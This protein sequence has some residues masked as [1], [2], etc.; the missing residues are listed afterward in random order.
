MKQSDPKQIQKHEIADYARYDLLLLVYILK[1]ITSIEYAVP[2]SELAKEMKQ[3]LGGSY[4]D[5]TLRRKLDNILEIQN[6]EDDSDPQKKAEK[7]NIA[8]I[9]Y[10]VYGGRVM[11]TGISYKKYYFEPCLDN[12]SMQMLN[13]T[14][15]SNRF[16][17][18]EEKAY[19]LTRM[20]MLNM[21]GD[22]NDLSDEDES[23]NAIAPAPVSEEDIIFPGDS[24]RF[25]RNTVILDYSISERYQV[26]ITYGTYDVY[27]NGI[28]FHTRTQD[29]NTKIYRLNPYALFWSDG[30]YYLLATYVSGYEPVYMKEKGTPVNFR[31]DRIVDVNLVK[32]KKKKG[33][34]ASDRISGRIKEFFDIQRVFD[35]EAYCARFP[36]MRIS[37]HSDLIDCSIECTPWSLQ[38]LV[39]TFGSLISVKE[40]RK[41]HSKEEV[42]YNGR[43]Q[44]F[45]EARIEKVEFENMRDFCLSHPEYITP[46][47]PERL[48]KA[49]RDKLNE[50]IR[51]LEV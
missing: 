49:V 14:V 26:D 20:K 7:E 18:Q 5:R 28:D 2:A 1:G 22:F 41:K 12:A 13:G 16:L 34:V 29:G 51:R 40:S 21:L 8:Q 15:L 44:T 6:W 36:L 37:E 33:Y 3:Y 10:C 50:C 17:S 27:E 43:E 30:H 42:D 35:S 31:V 11:T 39:D 23:E 47:E 19:L 46:L 48:V 9:M 38:I 24:S 4:S 32:D 45:I 25:I